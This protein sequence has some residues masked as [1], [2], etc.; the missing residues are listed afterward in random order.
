MGAAALAGDLPTLV[1][2]DW[3]C[4]ELKRLDAD[5]FSH[6]THTDF[7]QSRR[8]QRKLREWEVFNSLANGAEAPE[9]VISIEAPDGVHVI[10]HVRS[11]VLPEMAA[12]RG[13]FGARLIRQLTA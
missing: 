1:L 3:S 6:W 4:L 9:D 13:D 11:T 8:T 7:G 2:P 5:E 10:E 12:K